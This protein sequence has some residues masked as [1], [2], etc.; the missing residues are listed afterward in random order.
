MVWMMKFT[1]KG[2]GREKQ[3][4]PPATEQPKEP[5]PLP[6]ETLPSSDQQPIPE[7]PTR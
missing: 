2:S 7:I 5:P 4:P 6:S 1:N 3:A